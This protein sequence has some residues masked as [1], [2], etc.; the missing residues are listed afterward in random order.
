MTWQWSMTMSDN[1]MTMSDNDKDLTAMT[2]NVRWQWVAMTWQYVQQW[3]DNEWQW[4]WVTMTMSD[5]DNEFQVL[6]VT[7][8]S[9]LGTYVTMTWQYCNVIVI[10][11]T[12]KKMGGAGNDPVLY[13]QDHHCSPSC[14]TPRWVRVWLGSVGG[15]G[16]VGR[17]GRGDVGAGVMVERLCIGPRQRGSLWKKLW[18]YT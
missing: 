7:M 17:G 11:K 12:R 8:T 5:N 2:D 1:D 3:G 16:R 9:S 6:I 10:T 4:Q 15:E 13:F 18:L 14:L